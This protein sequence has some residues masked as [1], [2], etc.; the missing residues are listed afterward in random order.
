MDA[1]RS[2][3]WIVSIFRGADRRGRWRIARRCT[4]VNWMGG[5][6]LDLSHAELS[7]QRTQLNMYSWMGGGQ[8]KV[9]EGIAVQ[10]SKLAIMG[11]ND[12]HLG[13]DAP[14]AGAP[15]LRIRLISI[16]GGCSVR[17]VK[18]RTT[19]PAG[20]PRRGP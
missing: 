6:E 11:G 3:R 18:G 7:H 2:T 9:P 5:T 20:P 14:P 17:R 12:V 15:L 16:F 4:V 19:G 10:V 13:D 8:I 1:K